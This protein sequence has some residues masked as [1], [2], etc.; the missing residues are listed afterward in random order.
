M[1]QVRGS[2]VA[3]LLVSVAM[4][5]CGQGSVG[6]S[7]P[8]EGVVVD[9]ETEG[10]SDVRGF[11]LRT[12]DGAELV[13]AIGRLENPD[14]VAPAHLVEHLAS[15]EPVRVFFREED[16]GLLVYRL[17]VLHAHGAEG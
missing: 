6:P 3:A 5:A 10:L 14:E 1:T 4:G 16:G 2:L 15:S 7:S 8:V 13:F 12:G 9:V 17:E 11:T